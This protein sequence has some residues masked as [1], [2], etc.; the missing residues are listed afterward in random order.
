MSPTKNER[1]SWFFAI[2]ASIALG[3]LVTFG[4]ACI[5]IFYAQW[6][7]SSIGDRFVWAFI[8]S[9]IVGVCVMAYMLWQFRQREVTVRGIW[10][11]IARF[12]D[13]LGKEPF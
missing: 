1:E 4:L 3:A 5:I 7:A 13:A 8:P 9:G 12:W 10:R 6:N 11:S 2:A